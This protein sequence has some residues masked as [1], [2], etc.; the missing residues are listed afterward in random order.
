MR[1]PMCAEAG[2]PSPLKVYKSLPEDGVAVIRYRRCERC[3]YR[4]KTV[5]LDAQIVERMIDSEN[6]QQVFQA[7]AAI[8]D[9][10]GVIP[11]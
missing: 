3:G 9:R 4:A 7:A 1:C 6:A 5:E 11:H 10:M 2:H 8:S